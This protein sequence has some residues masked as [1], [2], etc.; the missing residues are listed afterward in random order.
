MELQ[1]NV[2]IVTGAGNGIGEAIARKLFAE[3]ARV[4]LWDVNVEAVQKLAAELD[5]EGRRGRSA[6]KVDVTVRG[7][8]PGRGARD[9]RAVRPHRR[10]GQQ[11]RHLPSHARSRR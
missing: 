10:A 1:G 5:P 11:R 2:A 7:G 6:I 4:A 8:G 3:G 9:G